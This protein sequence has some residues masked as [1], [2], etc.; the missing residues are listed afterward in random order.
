MHC[1]EAKQGCFLFMLDIHYRKWKWS[2]S[3][4]SDSLQPHGLQ[5]STGFSVPGIFQ[6]RVP[7]WV[8]ISFSRGS[9]RPKG[10]TRVSRIA[11]RRFTLWATREAIYYISP[12]QKIK[13]VSFTFFAKPN[14]TCTDLHQTGNSFWVLWLG[15]ILLLFLR[16]TQL[17]GNGLVLWSRT[18]TPI[19]GS[20]RPFVGSISVLPLCQV[21]E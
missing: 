21:W 9:S 2:C 7:G 8:A 13:H 17:P 12:P 1:K 11:G 4:V 19:Q 3:V 10:Q 16:L 18:V 6:A 20:Q 5:P 14:I 15:K